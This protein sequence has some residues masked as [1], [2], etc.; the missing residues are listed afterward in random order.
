MQGPYDLDLF[1]LQI[2]EQELNIK[3]I[4]MQIIKQRV[5]LKRWLGARDCSC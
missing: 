4:T 2:P 3:V 5:K 1:L